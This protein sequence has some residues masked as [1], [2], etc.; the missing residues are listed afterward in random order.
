MQVKT[1]F[2]IIPCV[3]VE[4]MAASGAARRTKSKGNGKRGTIYR[5]IV[6]NLSLPYVLVPSYGEGLSRRWS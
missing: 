4:S 5:N 1:L 3:D 2:I 6:A